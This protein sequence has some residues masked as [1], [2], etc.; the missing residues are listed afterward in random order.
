MLTK[1]ITSVFGLAGFCAPCLAWLNSSANLEFSVERVCGA[2][3]PRND[4][5]TYKFLKSLYKKIKPWVRCLSVLPE[6]NNVDLFQKNK[7]L[8]N[9]TFRNKKGCLYSSLL[10]IL[11]FRGS[12]PPDY[13]LLFFCT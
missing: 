9:A 13:L 7:S 2:Q 3:R 1:R 11:K 10:F 5:H 4:Q 8:T 6:N 12:L